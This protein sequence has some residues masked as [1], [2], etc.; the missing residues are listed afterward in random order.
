MMQLQNQVIYRH[1]LRNRKIF[2]PR[3]TFL[4]G[5]YD[6]NELIKR[7]RFPF[8]TIMR[9]TEEFE[10]AGFGIVCGK[11]AAIANEISVSS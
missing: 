3:K 1:F 10:A 4:D 9:M 5:T 8:D 7:F 6:D 2:R 11:S